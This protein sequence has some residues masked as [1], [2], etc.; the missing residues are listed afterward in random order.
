MRMTMGT[1]STSDSWLVCQMACVMWTTVDHQLCTVQKC[2]V[3]TSTQAESR[4]ENR[5]SAN[6]TPRPERFSLVV[7]STLQRAIARNKRAYSLLSMH[8]SHLG[9]N[10][11]CD[12]DTFNLHSVLGV[13]S[14]TWSKLYSILN[15]LPLGHTCLICF[16]G[17]NCDSQVAR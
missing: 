5:C 15:V 11:I 14:D 16:R 1:L 7:V 13:K 12:W 8:F 2:S 17:R 6:T 3:H 9:K 4:V 10:V